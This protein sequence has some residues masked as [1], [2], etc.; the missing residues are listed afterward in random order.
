[1]LSGLDWNG[2]PECVGIRS[3]TSDELIHKEFYGLCRLYRSIQEH[4]YNPLRWDYISGTLLKRHN[5]D[6]RFIP[7][8]GNHRT[9]IL[10]YLNHDS[11]LVS[12]RRDSYDVICEEEVDEWHYVKTGQCSRKDALAYFNAYF[13]LNGI[14]QAKRFGLI[15]MD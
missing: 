8:Q 3:P 2:C 1:M 13:E 6:T 10:S 15:A 14:E 9:A 4:G 12:S 7:L 11:I 5:G